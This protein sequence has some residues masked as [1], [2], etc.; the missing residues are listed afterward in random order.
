MAAVLVM[1]LSASPGFAEPEDDGFIGDVPYVPTPQD[2]VDAMLTIAQVGPQDYVIDLGS[3]DGRIVVTAAAKFGA[4]GFGVDLN[5]KRI[6]EA[7]ENAKAAGVSD[8][9]QFFQRDLFTTDFSK[10]TVLTMYLLPDI[11]LQLRPKVLDLKP[12]TRVV[13]HDFNM[14]D[15]EPDHAVTMR[16]GQSG[17][18]DRIYFWVVPA[19][20]A[21]QWRWSEGGEHPTLTLE[22]TFQQITPVLAGAK[23][24]KAAEG[25]LKGDRILITA[26]DDA[27]RMRIYA[28]RVVGDSIEGTVKGPDG[29]S[30]WQA[31]RTPANR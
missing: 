24:W 12:G 1:G 19:K 6:A 17:Y 26:K 28:G 20:V 16:S 5:P 25:I 23:G 3:G 22:Q 2:V 14:G 7:V 18:T 31:S 15:W 9:A 30:P 13:S 8:R 21:G 4:R 11:N 10:A 29:E 27:G